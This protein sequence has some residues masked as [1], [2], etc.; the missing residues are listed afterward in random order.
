MDI[1]LNDQSIKDDKSLKDDLSDIYTDDLDTFD[2]D[3]NIIIKNDKI[4]IE[5]LSKLKLINNIK[6]QKKDLIIDR[7]NHMPVIKKLN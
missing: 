3:D 4:N 1:F 2:I 7:I 5:I 6:S